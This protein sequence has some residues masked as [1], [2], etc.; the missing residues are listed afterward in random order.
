[1]RT[2]FSASPRLAV[3]LNVLEENARA[4]LRDLSSRRISLNA[5]TKCVLSHEKILDA[6]YKAG[7]KVFSD[8]RVISGKNIRI[9][10]QKRGAKDV[11][12]CLLKPPAKTELSEAVKYFDRFYISTVEAGMAIGRE[13][14]AQGKKV[15]LVLMVET[16]DLREGFLREELKEAKKALENMESVVVSG[17]GTNVAC[18]EKSSFS[19]TNIE[20]LIEILKECHFAGEIF[21][22]GGNSSA[23]YLLKKGDLPEFN[24]EL[25]IGEALLLGNDT[26]SYELYPGLRDDAFVLS[27]EVVEARQK[28]CGKIRVVI[29][30]GKADIGSG[31]ITPLNFETNE[32][33]EI[34]RSSDHTVFE[35][36]GDESERIKPGAVVKFKPSYFALLAAFASPLVDKV[37]VE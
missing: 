10:A 16:G 5:V 21:I 9:W 3:N 34:K 6:Y 19:K 13:A 32:L 35:W 28:G 33:C 15:E 27:A 20:T 31:R 23:L 36:N 4:L 26:I 2:Q 1:M 8:S 18:L 29:S 22:S 14:R 24:G 7:I 30:I 11:I 12:A 17:V 25:R 37:F